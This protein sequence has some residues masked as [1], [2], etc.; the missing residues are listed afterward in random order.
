MGKKKQ[1]EA[2]SADTDSK[3]VES[4]DTPPLEGSTVNVPV[5]TEDNPTVGGSTEGRLGGT[6]DKSPQPAAIGEHSGESKPETETLW[7]LFA[8]VGY[9]VW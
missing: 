1:P 8:K 2:C 6:V 7:S 9:L 5:T 4:G 3:V